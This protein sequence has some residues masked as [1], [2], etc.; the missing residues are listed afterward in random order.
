V[1]EGEGTFCPYCGK[2]LT[3]RHAD[4]FPIGKSA[5]ALTVRSLGLLL[6]ALALIAVVAGL[7]TVV[8]DGRDAPE[9]IAKP[10]SEAPPAD[11]QLALVSARYERPEGRGDL[12]F[13]GRVK[14]ISDAPLAGVVAV[15]S[16][17]DA[18][19]ALLTANRAPIE[20]A[21]LSPGETSTFR[22]KVDASPRA[23]TYGVIFQRPPGMTI[24]VRD[25]RSK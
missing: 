7:V 1:Q 19:P 21:V 11:A 17:Y 5:K 3:P 2:P 4:F 10:L 15:V 12:V 6:A 25:N 22:V 24:P 23:R 14:N 16:L 13:E 20:H 18:D 9:L 8:A